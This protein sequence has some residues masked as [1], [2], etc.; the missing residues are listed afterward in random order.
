M[1]SNQYQKP[2]HH[3]ELSHRGAAWLNVITWA[4][5]AICFLMALASSG[6]GALFPM[7]ILTV[8]AG[9]G[10]AANLL[11]GLCSYA[12]GRGQQAGPYL[13]G[14]VPLAAI[15]WWL[16]GEFSHIGKIGG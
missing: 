1:Q 12:T 16:V 13:I 8:A 7:L 14:F 10:A 11:M 6:Y 15:A 5:M 2:E 3:P 9:L 4:V